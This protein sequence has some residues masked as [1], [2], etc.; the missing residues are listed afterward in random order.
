M[1]ARDEN[2]TAGVRTLREAVEAW[3]EIAMEAWTPFAEQLRPVIENN[4]RLSEQLR[5]V[6]EHSARM[7]EGVWPLFLDA[8]PPAMQLNAEPPAD[9]AAFAA[10]LTEA[11]R[12]CA[13]IATLL[14]DTVAESTVE[15]VLEWLSRV[16]T[17]AWPEPAA[18]GWEAA[19]RRRALETAL[20]DAR[21][22]RGRLRIGPKVLGCDRAAVT[23]NPKDCEQWVWQQAR[24]N[25]AGDS[26][27]VRS[28]TPRR[29]PLAAPSSEATGLEEVL[30]LPNSENPEETLPMLVLG[31]ATLEVMDEFLPEDR[32]RLEVAV[33]Q[34]LAR[35]RP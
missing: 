7:M 19:A 31:A 28:T 27:R 11:V 1:A 8:A 30:V 26:R 33:K 10:A 15:A 21:E 4:A 9:F 32:D 18:D 35:R 24:N 12:T 22:P 2:R 23:L 20:V 13:T 34:Q 14:D 17:P 3:G 16:P 5:P 6:L 29:V 25:K